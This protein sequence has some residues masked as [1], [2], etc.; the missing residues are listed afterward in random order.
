MITMFAVAAVAGL[1][2]YSYAQNSSAV[3][4]SCSMVSSSVDSQPLACGGASCQKK[5]EADKSCDK[6]KEGCKAKC[7]KSC[8]KD[9][10]GCKSECKKKCDSG[11]DGACKK[12]SAEKQSASE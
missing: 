4:V 8:D 12:E 11:T 1:S 5:A 2:F 3:P 10:E 7:E 9:K 6:D